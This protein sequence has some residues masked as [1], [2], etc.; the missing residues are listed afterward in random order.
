LLDRPVGIV[1]TVRSGEND[2]A[3]FHPNFSLEI[4][5]MESL[6]RKK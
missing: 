5:L 2:D 1:V 6:T 4:G 3:E